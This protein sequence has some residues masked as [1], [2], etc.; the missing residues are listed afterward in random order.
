MIES[1]FET[2]QAE[3]FG[4]LHI[5][6]KQPIVEAP[7]YV[8]AIDVLLLWDIFSQRKTQILVGFINDFCY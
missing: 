2:D 6:V 3:D 5:G 8:G 1:S 4:Y 7:A